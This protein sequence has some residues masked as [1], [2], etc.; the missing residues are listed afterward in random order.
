MLYYIDESCVEAL[1]RGDREAAEFLEQ[2]IIHRRK[3]KNLLLATRKVFDKL[4]KS[5]Y[6]AD[7]AREY[8][9]ILRNR[10]SENKLILEK[11]SKYY[12][13]VSEYTGN[14][15]IEENGQ[16][17]I[18]LSVKEG[19]HADFTDKS[20][21]LVESNDDIAFYS[22]IGKY[23]LQKKGIQNMQISFQ[24]EIGGGDT[25]SIR[26]A[27]IIDERQRTCLC[28]ADSDMRYCGA[29]NG[30]TL[31]KILTVTKG[32]EPIFYEVYALKMHEIENLIPIELLEL[33]CEEIPDA[34]EGIRFLKKLLS[35]DCSDN[36]PVYY[37]DYKKGIKKEYF[38]LKEGSD[39]D[40][41]KKFR[42][43]EEYRKYWRSIIEQCGITINEDANDFVVP[44]VCER[45]LTH[46]IQ[47]LNDKW[48]ENKICDMVSNSYI[49]E[50]WMEIGA[51]I[52]TW[53]CVGHR[54]LS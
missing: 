2:L 23:Y 7:F 25:T 43:L 8:Y 46:T 21:L 44:G 28:I 22:L 35:I 42:K 45:I 3:C 37:F 26:L 11:A 6:L 14:Q 50:S 5:E 36:S 51:K 29:K 19:A 49:Y 40:K 1:S 18:L 27:S 13:V 4:S 9:R 53:G 20:I 32:R 24:N 12:K 15:K 41:V 38:F 16:E 39:K 48:E 34:C 54:I 30:G 10:S 33:V 17:C 31:E 47:Y 52:V